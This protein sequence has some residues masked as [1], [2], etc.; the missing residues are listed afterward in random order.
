M[1]GGKISKMVDSMVDQANSLGADGV[2]DFST[3]IGG[4]AGH[5]VVSGI[6]VKI[7]RETLSSSAIGQL[8]SAGDKLHA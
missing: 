5:C 3:L 6:A 7:L 8:R 2:V 4:D 1:G